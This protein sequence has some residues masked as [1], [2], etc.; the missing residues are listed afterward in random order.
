MATI[1]K[2]HGRVWK[3][4]EIMLLIQKWIDENTQIKLLSCTRKKPMW[5]KISAFLRAEGRATRTEM[6][7][8]AKQ[9]FIL[10]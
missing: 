4:Q 8:P 10:W 7:M 3:N 1:E 5:Q 9:E 2:P 6:K